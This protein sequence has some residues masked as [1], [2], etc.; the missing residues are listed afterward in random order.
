M[1]FFSK[2]VKIYFMFIF[3]LKIHEIRIKTKCWNKIS[4]FKI[5][6]AKVYAKYLANLD[7]L[8]SL[9]A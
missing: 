8:E 7:T 1:F 5:S 4:A 2:R 6:F 3:F 9:Y